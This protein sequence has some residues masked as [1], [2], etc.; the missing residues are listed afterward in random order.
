MVTIATRNAS[1]KSESATRHQ[2]RNGRPYDENCEHE[3]DF[4]HVA[5]LSLRPTAFLRA[6]LLRMPLGDDEIE[7]LTRRV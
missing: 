1:T 2:E 4:S 7:F 6:D 3:E 5:I